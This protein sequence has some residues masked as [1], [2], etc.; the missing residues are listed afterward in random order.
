M[1][2][3]VKPIAPYSYITLNKGK[4]YKTVE[5][6]PQA[7]WYHPDGRAAGQHTAPQVLIDVM[8][9]GTVIGIEIL[10]AGKICGCFNEE[11]GNG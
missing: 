7:T 10:T 11:G 2:D 6:G 8:E 3:D 4:V 9:D 1:H 5:M